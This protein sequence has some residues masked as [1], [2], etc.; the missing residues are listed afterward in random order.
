MRDFTF[1][2]PTRVLFGKGQIASLAREVPAGARVLLVAGAGSIRKNGVLEQVTAALGERL[3]AEAWGI[4]PN[5]DVTDVLAVLAKARAVNADF[6]L[7]VGGGSVADATKAAAGLARTEGD[8][9]TILSK[10]GR[11]TAAL[12][13]GVVMTAPG[14]GSETNASAAISNRA[15]TRKVVFTSTHCF[16]LFAVIDPETTYSLAPAQLANGIVDAFVHVTEQYLTY[17][18]GAALTDRLSEGVL[19]TLVE[20]GLRAF[21]QPSDYEARANLAW[22]SSL[23]LGGLLGTG[24]PQDWTTHHVSHELTALFGIE[25]ARSLAAVLPAVLR[26][27]R[28]Q[29]RDKLVQ[30]GAR[31]FGSTEGPA[32]GRAERAIAKTEEFFRAL[33]VPARLSPYGVRAGDLPRVI[34]SLK[35]SRRVRLGEKLDVTLDDVTQVLTLALA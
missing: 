9:W 23:A 21:T 17:P 34:A 15:T 20:Q 11:F 5:P 19:A 12:P 2:N 24:V 18:V 30:Y 35:A 25:H 13:I 29:K 7:A 8:A 32:E 22:A 33:G 16:P 26:H 14:T 31:V 6:L 28:T 27:R 10:G 4:Q 1:Y 3:V